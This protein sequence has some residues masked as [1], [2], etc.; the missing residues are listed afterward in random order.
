MKSK[1]K[2]RFK[3]SVENLMPEIKRYMED[4]SISCVEIHGNETLSLEP[5]PNSERSLWI[6]LW[7]AGELTTENLIKEIK[8]YRECH[9]QWTSCYTQ[10]FLHAVEEETKCMH[11]S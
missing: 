5:I 9:L 3:D 2:S 7:L 4:N 6:K 11:A 1:S 8:K 10:D